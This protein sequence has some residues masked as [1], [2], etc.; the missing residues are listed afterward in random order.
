MDNIEIIVDTREQKK[1]VEDVCDERGI[2]HSRAK[3]NYGDYGIKING[4]LQPFT[5][6]RK[7]DIQEI[8][9]NLSKGYER[10]CR[11]FERSDGNMAV[12]VHGNESDI[13]ERKYLYGAAPRYIIANLKRMRKNF[14]S[15]HWHFVDRN[16]PEYIVD[17]L[18]NNNDYPLVYHD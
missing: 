6:E 18:L 5:V 14:P 9:G 8:V 11:E 7:K 17:L 15:I 12:V 13:A 16:S 4:I 3:L 1:Y 2:K 10:F